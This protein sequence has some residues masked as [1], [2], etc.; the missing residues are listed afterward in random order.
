MKMNEYLSQ[1]TDQI[2]CQKVHKAVRAELQA[3][4]EDQAEAYESEGM[5]ADE[6]ME[7]A[8]LE[9]GDP[10]ETGVSRMCR[11]RASPSGETFFAA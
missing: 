11:R 10:V 9:M 3:H 1:V 5:S 4:L 7:K 8:V 6:A 2:R